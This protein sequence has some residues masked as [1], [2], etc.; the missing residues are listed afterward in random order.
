MQTQL[1]D[2]VLGAEALVPCKAVAK[3]FMMMFWLWMKC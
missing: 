1:C 2:S 3:D